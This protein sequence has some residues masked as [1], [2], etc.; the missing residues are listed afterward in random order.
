MVPWIKNQFLSTKLTINQRRKEITSS[1]KIKQNKAKQKKQS[2]SLV[3]LETGIWTVSTY[4]IDQNWAHL[5][6]IKSKSQKANK[7]GLSFCQ[8]FFIL[9]QKN[10]YS[11]KNIKRKCWNIKE[12]LPR[13]GHILGARVMF[14]SLTA[15]Y[16]SKH[17]TD[18]CKI[19]LTR[20]D[21]S[22]DRQ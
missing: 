4:A 11:H 7:R 21:L 8:R 6:M 17:V 14:F 3:L 18:I 16:L 22:H 1:E 2:I 5:N 15:I 10:S 13:C 20:L 9:I 19:V 12:V